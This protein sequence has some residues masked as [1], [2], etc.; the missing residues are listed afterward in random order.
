MSLG[1][2]LDVEGFRRGT[3][4]GFLCLNER[5]EKE[6]SRARLGGAGGPLSEQQSRV[7]A[8]SARVR[9]AAPRLR[10]AAET[11]SLALYSC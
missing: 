5:V 11:L 1:N 9:P 10:T 3:L 4:A 8:L 7:D 6:A 2:R